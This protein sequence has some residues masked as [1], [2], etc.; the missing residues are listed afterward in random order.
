VVSGDAEGAW[1]M[2]KFSY[3]PLWLARSLVRLA[4]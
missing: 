3:S 1:G 2:R 4:C